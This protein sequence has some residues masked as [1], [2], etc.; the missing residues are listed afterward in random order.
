VRLVELAVR[1][2]HE[3]ILIIT[4]A[5]RMVLNAE[6]GVRSAECNSDA[7]PDLDAMW[8][9]EVARHVTYLPAEQIDAPPA[10]GSF[11]AAAT[12]IIPCSMNTLSA[13]AHGRAENLLQ[14]AGH[15]ALKEGRP[16]LVVPR[17]MPVTR[18]DLEN[19]LRLARAGAIVMPAMPGFYHRPKSVADL[20]DFVVAKV[21]ARLGIEHD[22]DIRWPPKRGD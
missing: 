13:L 11:G 18:I 7:A 5:G 2:G 6:C 10:S 20:V 22:L 1:A 4:R 19:M 14:R 17:E 9:G 8:P 3:V 12:V 15:V 16:L 21:L